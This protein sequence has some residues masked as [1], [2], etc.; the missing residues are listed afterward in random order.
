M[1]KESKEQESGQYSPSREQ[2]LPREG[3]NENE[4][5][6]SKTG[7]ADQ[8]LEEEED[9]ENED[10]EEQD[11]NTQATP[12]SSVRKVVF[13]I[14]P[15]RTGT[16][17]LGDLFNNQEDYLYFFE[18]LKAVQDYNQIDYFAEADFKRTIFYA[19]EAFEFLRDISRCSFRAR[20]DRYLRHYDVKSIMKSKKLSSAYYLRCQADSCMPLNHTTMNQLCGELNILKVVVK[21]LSFRMPYSRMASLEQLSLP[22]DFEILLLHAMRDPRAFFH[23]KH[24]LGWFGDDHVNPNKHL[25]PYVQRSCSL[26]Q[27]NIDAFK[28][29]QTGK[30]VKYRLF[31][32]E[33]LLFRNLTLFGESVGRFLGFPSTSKVADFFRKK[34]RGPRMRYN[35]QFSTS[36]RDIKIVINKWRDAKETNFTFVELIQTLCAGVMAELGYDLVA[37]EYHER[38]TTVSLV[39]EPSSEIATFP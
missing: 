24:K 21:E 8:E 10:E 36:S 2:D 38:D 22:G 7:E 1:K 13:V 20:N 25:R 11:L 18:P 12:P 37:S 28:G 27:Q 35:K 33:D 5:V 6:L 19:E 31:R 16:S 39:K 15:G 3:G 26:I 9:D 14:G 4:N 32:Y 23:S 34:T 17:L 29:N 30:R